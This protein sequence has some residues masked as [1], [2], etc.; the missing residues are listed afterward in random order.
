MTWFIDGERLSDEVRD[1]L[2]DTVSVL[3]PDQLQSTLVELGGRWQLD[4]SSAPSQLFR[5]AND[6]SCDVVVAPD[7]VIA[8]KA[9]KN[10]V[11]L[12][13]MR[14][15]HIRDGAAVCRFVEWLSEEGTDRATSNNPITELEAIE[16]FLGLRREVEGFHSTSFDTICG[17]GDNGAIV[18]YRANEASN[19]AVQDGELVL[20]DSGGQY[21]DGTTD[22]T[23]VIAIGDPS[24]AMKR[25]YTLVLKGHLALHAAVFPKGT[26]GQEIDCLARQYLWQEGLDYDHGT[27]HGVGAFLNVHEGPA[28]IAKARGALVPLEPGMVLSNEPG[29]YKAGEYGIRIE[30]L[31]IVVPRSDLNQDGREL[32]GFETLTFAPYEPKLIDT[33]LLTTAETEAINLYHREVW[34]KVSPSLDETTKTWLAEQTKPLN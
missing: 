30:N 18:H 33:E 15:A 34:E 8:M 19:R 29:F 27:G 16:K 7:P 14:A 9:T 17:S 21:L 20:V 28:R 23:R 4:A 10:R 32:Y 6:N 3:G 31:E 5:L 25:H 12:E 11:E 24:K 1:H 13:G 22:I 26:S 2:P